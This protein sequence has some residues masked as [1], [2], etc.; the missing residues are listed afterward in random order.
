M[1]VLVALVAFLSQGENEF[2]GVV[3]ATPVVR[4]EKKSPD[5]SSTQLDWY[6][7]NRYNQYAGDM[8]A[9]FELL[10]VSVFC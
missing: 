2:L 3:M 5:S 4:L 7:I 8:L 6:T 10:L 9:A 1:A